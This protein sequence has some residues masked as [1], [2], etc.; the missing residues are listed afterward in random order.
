MI[1]DN[2]KENIQVTNKEF[3]E[4][5][6]SNTCPWCGEVLVERNGKYGSFLGCSNYPKCRYT[7]K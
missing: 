1:S 3:K 6:E 7:K 5:I 4:N 2:T